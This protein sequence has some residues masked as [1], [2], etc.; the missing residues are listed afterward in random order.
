MKENKDCCCCDFSLSFKQF[1]VELVL[2]EMNYLLSGNKQ[3]LDEVFVIFTVR[4]WPIKKA[5]VSSMYYSVSYSYIRG[6]DPTM[7][8]STLNGT[9]DCTTRCKL[10]FEILY[11]NLKV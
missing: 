5:T 3:L 9:G 10:N 4:I 2:A 1:V 7:R 8:H 11:S 6:S